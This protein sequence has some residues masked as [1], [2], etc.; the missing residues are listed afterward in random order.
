M[1]FGRLFS[2][3][4]ESRLPC[5]LGPRKSCLSLFTR[6][7]QKLLNKA[8]E[9]D[10]VPDLSALLKGKLQ[11]LS[12]KSTSAGA[13]ETTGSEDVGASK[14]KAPSLVD[15]DVGAEPSASSPKKKKSEKAK[16]NVT[17][18]QQTTS[19][20]ENAPLEEA[21]SPDKAPGGPKKKKRSREDSADDRDNAPVEG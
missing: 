14:E 17:A 4:W 16:R 12:K 13:S 11:L 6:K 15:E 18:G 9:M 1:R 3:D 21:V 19:L 8:R 7:Q 20:D 10:G 5:V 2:V